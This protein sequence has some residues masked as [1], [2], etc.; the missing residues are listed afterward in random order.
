MGFI[1]QDFVGF[2]ALGLRPI[3]TAFCSFYS[4]SLLCEAESLLV[5]L[6]CFTFVIGFGRLGTRVVVDDNPS[7]RLLDIVTPGNLLS[8][9]FII[10]HVFFFYSRVYNILSTLCTDTL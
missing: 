5:V 9:F 7:I 6:K 1:L 8:F 2:I 4:V 10:Q 3:Y